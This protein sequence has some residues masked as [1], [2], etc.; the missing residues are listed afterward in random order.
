M[1][2]ELPERVLVGAQL[3]EVQPVAVDVVDVAELARV[4]ELLEPDQRPGGTRAGG[5]PSACGPLAS[6]AATTRSAS[7]TDWA[8]GFSTKH[9]LARL[10][11]ARASVGVRG[12]RRGEHQGVELRVGQQ[13]VEVAGRPA[14][15]RTRAERSRRLGAPS[16]SHAQPRAGS[17]AKLRARLGPQ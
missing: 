9:V 7:A 12:H 3:A 1:R 4:D 10:E 15:G 16:Q 17:A 13:L 2:A 5:R 14:A 8:S 6:A 11:G